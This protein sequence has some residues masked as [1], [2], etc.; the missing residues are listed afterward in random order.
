MHLFTMH[1]K[2]VRSSLLL[3]VGYDE[4]D[5]LLEIQFKNSGTYRYEGV[6]SSVYQGLMAAESKGSYF[7]KNIRNKYPFRKL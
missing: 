7:D 6:P 4:G 3:T 2:Y 1:R 5:S